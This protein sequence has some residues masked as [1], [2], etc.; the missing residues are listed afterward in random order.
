MMRQVECA[1]LFLAWIDY[2]HLSTSYIVQHVSLI[3]V[4]QVRILPKPCFQ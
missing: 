2:L 3:N 4:T 1:P